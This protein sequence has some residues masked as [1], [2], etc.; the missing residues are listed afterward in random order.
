MKGRN[1]NI[2]LADPNC[3]PYK[4]LG[5]AAWDLKSNEDTFELKL[6]MTKKVGTG[7]FLE[8]DADMCAIILPRSGQGSKYGL[9]LRNTIGLIDPDY[10]GELIVNLSTKTKITVER[11]DRIAQLLFLPYINVVN[12]NVTQRLASTTRGDGGFGSSGV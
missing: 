10:R 4:H 8:M 7:V 11:Y 5:G 6:G 2:K 3:N 1:L 9:H 12:M